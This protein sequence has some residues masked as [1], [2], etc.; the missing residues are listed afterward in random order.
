MESK[1][2]GILTL[3]FEP[4]YGWML[5][6]WAL[7]N[8]LHQEGYDVTVLDRR[9]N[10]KSPS[11]SK[12]V[13]RWIYYNV[14]CGQ[15]TQFFNANFT[16]TPQLR[17][18]AEMRREASSLDTLIVGSDQVWR[19]ENTRGADLNF[20]ADFLEARRDVK[21][22]AYAASFGNDKWAGTKEETEK[23]SSLL[24]TFDLVSVREASGVTMCKNLFGVLAQHVVDPT[25]LLDVEVYKKLLHLH[26]H[27]AKIVATYLLDNSAA[28][29]A[30]VQQVAN[31]YDLTTVDLY[32]KKRG[33]FSFYKSIIYWL[34]S[35][36]NAEKVVI[37]SFHGMIFSIL[38]NKQFV[39]LGNEKRGMA[40]FQSLLESLGISDRL[41]NGDLSSAVSLFEKEIDYSS[42][43]TRLSRLR[44]DSLTMLLDILKK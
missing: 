11:L 24:K 37:D 1:R 23:V 26:E 14:F 19:I 21:R 5:Q 30:F 43:N 27:S 12:S 17:S 2:I 28:K 25:M 15:F 10:D 34:E 3:P 22:I 13:Q 6:L 16:K 31:S 36:L 29:Q 42:V 9:W 7:Y 35:I 20:F 41:I 40:R 44:K 8:T 38:F 39:V 18:S 32:P 33:K 4:N